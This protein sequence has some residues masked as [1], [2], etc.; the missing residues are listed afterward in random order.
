MPEMQLRGGALDGLPIHYLVEGRGP[1]LLFVHG[2]GGFAESWRHNIG[3]LARQ[4]TVYALD[5]PGFGQS[6][7]PRAAYGLPF[8]TQAIRAFVNEMGLGR[9]TL[10]G[11][12]LGGA[13]A[14][15]YAIAHPADV[16]RVA[17]VGAV[18]P[19]FGYRMSWIYRL[20]AVPGIGD[21]LS[22]CTP[23]TVYR[24]VIARCFA[25]PVPG[26]VAFLVGWSYAAR[27]SPEGRGAYLGTLRGVRAD[28]VDHAEQYR[29]A[30]RQLDVPVLAIHGRQDPVVPPA[31]CAE[32]VENCRRGAVRWLNRCGHF[33]QIEHAPAV[34]A[35]L[36]EF[37]VGRTAPR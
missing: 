10:V 22:V 13:M 29:T 25:E 33:P 4:A 28:F 3:Y 27:T 24:T 19:G 14:L 21:V 6:G 5:L 31:H 37:L 23:A 12:S 18:A 2:L 36:A 1:A 9:L 30:V 35:W 16:E 20:L 8:F 11:H 15:A 26:E 32:V 34:N 7:K 17:L